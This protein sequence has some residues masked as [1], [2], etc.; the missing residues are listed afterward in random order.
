MG[1]IKNRCQYCGHIID[2]RE[3]A[4]F[5]GMVY[6]LWR[7]FEWCLQKDIH[8]FDRKDIEQFLIGGNEKA[9]FG[10]WVM[11]GGLVYKRAKG[12]YGINIER[13][14][15]F[16]ANRLAIPSRIWKDPITGGL[17]MVDYKKMREIPGLVEFLD[18]NKNYKARYSDRE[19]L[20]L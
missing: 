17:D 18:E 13:C 6:A 16:F 5:D 20:T 14:N 8:E 4:L 11:F 19:Q 15:D 10:D 2:K 12:K 7:V 3:I 1:C 9:R